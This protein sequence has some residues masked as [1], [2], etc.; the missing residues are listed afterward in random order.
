MSIK[1][2][3]FFSLDIRTGASGE[4]YLPGSK[5][6]SNRVVLLSALANKKIEIIN[7]LESEDTA[8]MLAI[9]DQLGVR[10]EKSN[11]LSKENNTE[12]NVPILTVHGIGDRLV[13]LFE[14]PKKLKIFVGNS[15]LTIRT[16]IPIFVALLSKNSNCPS[17]EIDGVERMRQRPIG[18]LV[19]SLKKI[20]AKISYMGNFG[21]P[22]LMIYP[23]DTYPV[24]EINV[25]SLESSQFLTG[26]IQSAPLLGKTWKSPVIIKTNQEIPSRP[27]IDLTI[28]ILKKFGVKVFETKKGVF[29]VDSFDLD[30]PTKFVIEGDASSAS[31]FLAS[32]VLGNGPIKLHG[33]GLKSIQG[34]IRIAEILEK[35]GAKVLMSENSI[36]ISKI[37]PLKG[38][39]VDCKNIPD[40][41][42]VLVTCALYAEGNTKLINIGSWKIK[43]T[44]RFEAMKEGVIK[45]GGKV[46]F[47]NDWIEVEPPK[48]LKTAY[49]KTY[50]D[51]R[52]AMSFSLA[53][54]SHS[55]DKNNI[56]RE[57]FFDNPECVE[58]TYPDYFDE[59]SRICSQAVKVITID[60]PT[61]SGKGTIAQRVSDELGFNVLD[62]GCFY[63]VLALTS[64]QENIADNDQLSLAKCANR[65]K[66]DFIEEKVFVG[67]SDV[68]K[69]IREEHIGIRASK[70]SIFVSVRKALLKV[71]RDFARTPGLVADGRDMGSIVFPNAFLKVF[72]SADEKIR[73]KRRY[74]QL[75]QKEIPCKLN[76][77]LQE[78]KQRDYRDYN[79]KSGSLNLAKEVC[80][81]HIDTSLKSIDEVVQIIINRFHETTVL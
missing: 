45:L 39:T 24:K 38:L 32:G 7:F 43:E 69:K 33:L 6:I 2:K 64:L 66:V 47:G 19:E 31:Y 56:E 80:S 49:I 41:S 14:S 57:V 11:I 15:G 58:K 70:I 72:L 75:I 26:L 40:A 60:G 81:I 25:S 73:A 76:D 10:Y 78:I 44:D 3:N 29:K 8:V 9:M 23:S 27:Y 22:P 21:F 50:N 55:G 16:I 12:T 37:R 17:I 62:S 34:D 79:R 36:E 4:V 67:N 59:F 28:K 63:R 13:N 71:Q 18:S 35:M 52:I 1:G 77:L 20:G 61:A 48:K 53:S 51:H 30:S 42:M 74:K 54:F 5:S 46:F 65:L 68:T